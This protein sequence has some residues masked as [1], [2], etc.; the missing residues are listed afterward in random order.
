MNKFNRI[1][2]S[3][4]RNDMASSSQNLRTDINSTE[5]EIAR[6]ENNLFNWTI[7]KLNISKIYDGEEFCIYNTL[8]RPFK[9]NV[10]YSIKTTEQT[11][12]IN[13]E[14]ES[15]RLLSKNILIDLKKKIQLFTYWISSDGNQTII[16]IGFR[17]ININVFKRC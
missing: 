1:L 14:N 15:I 3:K 7:P 5:I 10:K 11:I 17:Y 4:E 12:A 13:Q 6:I 9:Q 8:S 16:Q 2:S